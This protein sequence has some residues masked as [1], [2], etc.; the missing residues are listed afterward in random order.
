[1]SVLL[2]LLIA[3]LFLTVLGHAS[4]LLLAAIFHAVFGSA[5]SQFQVGQSNAGNFT[6]RNENS[7][8]QFRSVVLRMVDAGKIDSAEATGLIERAGETLGL[9]LYQSTV[10]EGAENESDSA[11]EIVSIVPPACSQSTVTRESVQENDE[12][13]EV[14]E[15]EIEEAEEVIEAELVMLATESV[16]WRSVVGSFLEQRNIR[17]GE[18]A[19]GLLIVFCSIGLVGSLWTTLTATHR[20]IP[21]LIFM[22]ANAAI[23]AAGFY[24]LGRWRIRTTSRA[25]LIIAG[26]LVPL[27]VLAGLAAAGQGG[28]NASIADPI[29]L[30][31]MTVGVIAYGGLLKRSG[32]LLVGKPLSWSMMTGILGPVIL[33]P[34]MPTVVRSFGDQ[35]GWCVLLA[36]LAVCGSWLTEPLLKYNSRK[37]NSIRPNFIATLSRR[38]ASIRAILMLSGGFA[39][40]CLAAYTAFLISK[41]QLGSTG[42]QSFLP[43]AM[44]LLPAVVG[45]SSSTRR[46]AD[47]ATDAIWRLAGNTAACLGG[48]SIASLLMVVI[49]DADWLWAWGGLTTLAAL[50]VALAMR[51]TDWITLACIPIALTIVLTSTDWIGNRPFD[52]L[53]V[54][55]R[56]ISGPTLLTVAA[57][58]FV[59]TTAS[60]VLNQRRLKPE[61]LSDL[62]P[63]VWSAAALLIAACLLVGPST[64]M[65]GIPVGLI[66]FSLGLAAVGCIASRQ[67]T[68]DTI[69]VGMTLICL[70]H[71]A[72]GID[73]GWVMGMDGLVSTR[74][75]FTWSAMLAVTTTLRPIVSTRQAQA[76]CKILLNA[77]V[78]LCGSAS[79][80]WIFRMI[81]GDDQHPDL[82]SNLNNVL[83]PGAAW[84]VILARLTLELVKQTQTDTRT[85]LGL[86]FAGFGLW[87]S[88]SVAWTVASDSKTQCIVAASMILSIAA[89][90][91]FAVAVFQRGVSPDRLDESQSWR[92]PLVL[93]S[94]FAAAITAIISARLV[95]LHWLKALMT[96]QPIDMPATSAVILWWL[97]GGV[98]A[99]WLAFHPTGRSHARNLLPAASFL[100]VGAAVLAM[101]WLGWVHPVTLIQGSALV[102][103]VWALVMGWG[104]RRLED[105][106]IIRSG[107]D[108]SLAL[109]TTAEGLTSIASVVGLA[110]C[111]ATL[112]ALVFQIDSLG[113]LFGTAS[114]LVSLATVAWWIAVRKAAAWPVAI[115]LL[116][117]HAGAMLL[118]LNWITPAT[119]PLVMVLIW[120]LAAILSTVRF[121]AT[122]KRPD[123]RPAPIWQWDR[124]HA[125]VMILAVFAVCSA[126]YPGSRS[127][128]PL[129]WLG[130]VG[131]GSLIAGGIWSMVSGRRQESLELARTLMG[132]F[133]TIGGAFFINHT[134]A[135]EMSLQPVIGVSVGWIVGW[136]VAWR[137][138]CPDQDS[139][140]AALPDVSLMVVLTG[141][142]G[143]LCFDVLSI[144]GRFVPAWTW[145]IDVLV[146]VSALM[147]LATTRARNGRR[148]SMEALVGLTMLAAMLVGIKLGLLFQVPHAVLPVC[149][150]LGG[151]AWIA[152]AAFWM[153]SLVRLVSPSLETKLVHQ[154]RLVQTFWLAATLVSVAAAIAVVHYGVQPS[155][156]VAH[157]CVGAIAIMVFALSELSE[158][159]RRVW[160]HR[161]S[162]VRLHTVATGLSMVILI[163]VVESCAESSGG[164]FV[165]LS[166]SM[167]IVVAMTLVI[168][169]LLFGLPWLL[170]STMLLR[171][172]AAM[173]QGSFAAGGITVLATA[174]MLLLEMRYRVPGVGITHLPVHLVWM[175]GCVLAGLS[176][177]ATLVAVATGP[178][179]MLKDRLALTD[180]GRTAAIVAAQCLAAV[181][182][183][184]KYL[185]LDTLAFLGM[186][187]YWPYIVM[188]LAMASVGLTQWAVNRKDRVL[189]DQLRRTALFLPVVPIVG[190]WMSAWFHH[191][192]GDNLGSDLASWV[193]GGGSVPYEWLIMMTAIYYIGTSLLWKRGG[194]RIAGVVLANVALWIWLIQ[195]PGWGFLIHPQAWLIPPAVCVLVLAHRARPSLG[196]AAATA[197]R[198]AATLVIYIS[199]TADML[200]ADIGA[201]LAGP[202]VLIL[203]A[204]AG[205]AAGVVLRVRSFLFLGLT[206]VVMGLLSMIW[207]AQQ[208][209]E[210]VWPWWVFGISTGCLILV[211][212]AMLEKN[213]PKLQRH[214]D[215]LAAWEV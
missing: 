44:A 84:L 6:R 215:Q 136:I 176:A 20:V 4:W 199:S 35:A 68:A 37:R 213:K 201:T 1:M 71:L 178:G 124:W 3:W 45:F 141:M 53:M 196:A 24:T 167:R 64:W 11:P 146:V 158:Q 210:A 184:H 8:G 72:R 118:M 111:V 18:I 198:T 47:Q 164:T 80:I 7:L 159:A 205:M 200:I 85:W 161:E 131:I 49:G 19:A 22:S 144:P 182:W 195:V 183:L 76:V 108:L 69:A 145:P 106:Q 67:P 121:A 90:A 60:G 87:I 172:Q 21:S 191:G 55:Q 5:D 174:T 94:G 156:I 115:T 59:W 193:F 48:L 29:L 12:V 33:L 89:V 88:A 57:I 104:M 150:L 79:L 42:Y 15:A 135:S 39:M 65:A 192:A 162:W 56:V 38:G 208:A 137:L 14:M 149:G 157:A 26:L 100:L 119:L 206:F 34:I 99:A 73:T 123:S 214:L 10:A 30:L 187:A 194:P 66:V 163:A 9:A 197:I 133:V 129:W 52:S 211:G 2:I 96:H 116:S 28:A 112:L 102:A 152:T 113:F 40:L 61:L 105:R 13:Q 32:N 75:F 25:V 78:L 91:W 179:G 190:F 169:T 166:I 188:A 147:L 173:R 43:L 204:L 154:R 132:Y 160:K 54:W 138:I 101:P 98:V 50:S 130:H 81:A 140:V 107:D 110:T 97:I 117:G 165:F 103:M 181:T 86:A 95:S 155:R 170:G 212:L 134:V 189:A 23:F 168:P 139:S 209:I 109:H 122:F 93:N 202:I 46:Y 51:R 62:A 58:A 27:S 203:L 151:A 180:R 186:R 16:S 70:A 82:G 143:M 41:F 148:G 153:E 127:G 63:L 185:C 114:L 142:L 177:L 83:I 92:M 175:V 126:Y 77:A 31:A 120:M 74:L 207:H 128:D 125:L 171:W 17:W 36:S